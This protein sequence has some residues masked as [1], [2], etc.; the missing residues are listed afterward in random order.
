MYR[1]ISRYFTERD[2]C[3]DATSC[4][5]Y[6]SATSNNPGENFAIHKDGQNFL[7]LRETAYKKSSEKGGSAVQCCI[8][9]LNVSVEWWFN[10]DI[11]NGNWCHLSLA[12]LNQAVG[13][14]MLT[15][16]THSVRDIGGEFIDFLFLFMLYFFIIQVIKSRKIICVK[17][18]ARMVGKRNTCAISEKK[19]GEQ[20]AWNIQ[21][22]MWWKSSSGP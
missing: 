3:P 20:T 15:P 19:P 6:V 21:V 1:T 9:L 10:T 7:P 12:N 8:L 13:P 11:T 2:K 5:L 17:H 16:S 4:V 14:T 22:E 18:A